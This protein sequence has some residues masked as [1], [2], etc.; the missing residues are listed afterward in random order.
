MLQYCRIVLYVIVVVC[1]RDA[2]ALNKNQKG[3]KEGGRRGYGITVSGGRVESV[4]S[5]R[6]LLF[7]NA[8]A[9]ALPACRLPSTDGSD[10]HSFLRRSSFVSSASSA[11]Q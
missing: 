5:L 6:S 11:D 4:R 8:F 9:V 10:I 1:M 7:L 2:L 3:K